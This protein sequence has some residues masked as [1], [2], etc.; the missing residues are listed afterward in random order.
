MSGLGTYSVLLVK[1]NGKLFIELVQATCLVE[2]TKLVMDSRDYKDCE[3]IETKTKVMSRGEANKAAA[4]AAAEA[5]KVKKA[6]VDALEKERAKSSAKKKAQKK[7]K[8]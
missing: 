5:L 7:D 1:P 8:K 3:H 4:E 6:A 2:A